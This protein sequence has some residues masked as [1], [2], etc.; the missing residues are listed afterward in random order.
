MNVKLTFITDTL[1][2]GG[3]E[4]VMS[5]L[6]NELSKRFEVEIIC[7]RTHT[8]YYPLLPEVKV[9]YAIDYCGNSLGKKFLWLRKYVSKDSLVIAFMVPVYVFTLASLMFTRHR[10]IVSERNDPDAASTFRRIARKLLIW[11]A[12]AVVVQTQS[13]ADR[14]PSSVRNKQT[15]IY[16]PISDKYTSGSAL[17][18]EKKDLIVSVGRLSPQKN[19]KMMIDGFKELLNVKPDYRL[20]IYGEGE[21]HEE[22]ESYIKE[23][24]L[25]DKVLLKGRCNELQNVL[26]RAKFFVLTSDYEGMSNA[27]MEA[28]YV[29]LPVVTTA[30]SGTEELIVNGENG[31]IVP[32]R[33]TKAYTDAIID[34]V[35][36]ESKL[37]AMAKKA[38]EIKDKIEINSI[39]SRWTAL[40]EKVM[41]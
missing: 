23:R 2:S 15:I 5:V 19:Q 29:G 35:T 41:K 10:V 7:L 30:V 39:V 8:A 9:T 13:I 12:Q 22:I 25:A 11:R 3:S 36:N 32:I 28:L 26:N 24:G 14:M 21:I 27:M 31:V 4:R 18:S 33:D 34:L 6:A 38:V 37:K 17:G 20:E 16:N 1:S 40:I